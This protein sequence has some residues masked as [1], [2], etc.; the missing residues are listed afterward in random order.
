MPIIKANTNKQ[1]G[2]YFPLCKSM[3]SMKVVF[4]ESC[5]YNSGSEQSDLHKLH[6]VGVFSLFG[7]FKTTINKKW[8]EVHKWLS[9]RVGWR[10]N[11]Q[12]DC[13][14]VTDYTY[15]NGIGERI[16]I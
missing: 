12:E 7:S 5:K 10:Y 15:V 6:G 13:F 16:K 8:W 4:T 2:I 9:I 3:Q 1:A 11:I 14:E